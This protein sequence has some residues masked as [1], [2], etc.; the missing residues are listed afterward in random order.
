MKA[1]SFRLINKYLSSGKEQ[2]KKEKQIAQALTDAAAKT[3][4][5]ISQ[6]LGTTLSGLSEEEVERQ[7]AQYGHNTVV[8]EKTKPWYIQLLLAFKNPF[9]FVLILLAVISFFTNDYKGMI[10]IIVM[11]LI[12]VFIKFI[13]EYKSGR[14]AES[15]RKMVHITCTVIRRNSSG[16]SVMSEIPLSRLVPGD[17]VHLAAGDII[18]A[19]VRLIHSKDLFISQS[20]LTG[21]SVPIEKNENIIKSAQ[22]SPKNVLELK[23]ICFMGTNV[24][25][26]TAT[27]VVLST[28]SETYFGSMAATLA[29]TSNQT[30]FDLG[31]NKVSWL[32]IRFMAVMVPVV[33][34]ITGFTKGDWLDALMFALSIAVGLTPEMLPMVV[35]SNLAKG[36]VLMA[37]EKVIVKKLSAIQDFGAM[38]VLCTDKTG[39]LTEDR[40]VLMKYT[41]VYINE[42]IKALRYAFLNSH[43]ETGLK[44]AMDMAILDSDYLQDK[45]LLRKSWQVVDE[46]PF[47][48][49]RRRM[50]VILKQD[51]KRILICKGAVEEMLSC[52]AKIDTPQ[53]EVDATPEMKQLV[54]RNLQ[55]L[56]RDGLRVLAVGHKYFTAGHNDVYTPAEE[57]DLVL[58]GFMS[59]L[60]P[61]KE[62][63]K[64]AIKEL[65]DNGIRVMVLTGDN[66]VIA[67]KVCS[68]VGLKDKH[69]V[70]GSDIEEL[71]DEEAITLIEQ[72]HIFAKLAPMQ[73][74]RIV[75]LLRE[76]GYV[77]GYM[78]DGINDA[79][80]LREADI[81]ISVDTAVDIAKESAD[82][83]LLQ[84]SLLV[85]NKGVLEGRKMF[86]N[87][88]KYIKITASSNFGNVFS[89]LGASILFP[90]LPML[91]LQILILNLIYDIS[92]IAI[93]WDNVD[94]EY[95][96]KPRKWQ[97]SG[98]KRFMLIIGPTSSI[99]DYVTFAVLFFVFGA[100]T[101]AQ[102]SFFQTGWFLESLFTQTLIVQILRTEKIPFIQ[103]R[104]SWQLLL[105]ALILLTLGIAIP[106][107]A[108]GHYIGF[109][110]VP[111][112]FYF[113]LTGIM[114]A[115]CVLTQFVKKWYVRKFNSW[116]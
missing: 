55:G 1:F 33:F 36:A 52:V 54:T 50:S 116:I 81:G 42:S 84:K 104:S 6:G 96:K 89:L 38:D 49:E 13:E 109:Y 17:I 75:R 77:V 114:I 70:L 115:Y 82:I 111:P 51:D 27:A 57:F 47:D 4:E 97:A 23:N 29:G 106:Y 8:H 86:A 5:E 61:P 24:N 99:F 66:D 53:G 71:S 48:F 35:T 10:I 90:F 64:K 74:A 62:S 15:L 16:E 21:E 25:S 91:P 44:N 37:K 105:S 41:D 56:Y 102:Q 69:V 11:I 68:E 43:F 110:P 34:F 101:L 30:S 83:I 73:K 88:M 98:I 46:L 65:K 78:G 3:P 20:S 45:E 76:K 108:I 9:N 60:D 95:L 19:D 113:W 72:N 87:T 2:T 40:I 67:R 63:A 112:A 100:N 92:Q 7:T 12:S 80:A 28:G 32:L 85:L 59:F 14:S 39:T 94:S 22:D 26:G 93:P 18:P 58:D 31:I 79:V 107:T 103:S